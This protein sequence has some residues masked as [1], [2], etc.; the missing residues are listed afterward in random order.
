MIDLPGI[1][2]CPMASLHM[3]PWKQHIDS[4][5]AGCSE[6]NSFKLPRADM[7]FLSAHVRKKYVDILTSVVAF[8]TGSSPNHSGDGIKR[9]FHTWICHRCWRH[10]LTA[11]RRTTRLASC[12]GVPGVVTKDS[13][14]SIPVPWKVQPNW[15]L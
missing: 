7:Y 9:T 4:K 10:V 13:V 6:L 12:H 1:H 11:C 14:K 8:H 15:Q 2:S 5:L 3:D